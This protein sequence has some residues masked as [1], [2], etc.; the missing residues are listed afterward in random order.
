MLKHCYM[1]PNAVMLHCVADGIGT[2][3]RIQYVSSYASWQSAG[4]CALDY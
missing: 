1:K 3:M 4:G 2:M